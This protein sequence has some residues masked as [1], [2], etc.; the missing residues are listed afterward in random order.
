MRAPWPSI[1]DLNLLQ[2]RVGDDRLIVLHL[3]ITHVDQGADII[4][5]DRCKLQTFALD[6]AQRP[7][8]ADGVVLS[9]ARQT[10]LWF[11]HFPLAFNPSSTRRL[12]DPNR[13]R[14]GSLIPSV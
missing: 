14:E 10:L 6:V 13:C 1:A 7:A 9:E 2:T 4:R 8:Q 11:V 12:G 3:D 5:I